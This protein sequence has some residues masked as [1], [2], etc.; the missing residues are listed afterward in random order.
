V[1]RRVAGLLP[2]VLLPPAAFAVHQ[3]RFMLAFGA[4]A[5]AELHRTGHSYL[6]SVVPWLVALVGLAVGWML[7]GVGRALSG[8]RTAG[9][10]AVSLTGLW[11]LCTVALVAIYVTQ[12]SLEGL[13]ATGHP[14]GLAG[15]FGFGGWWAVFVAA[16]VGLV[17]A[18]VCH[19]AVWAIDTIATRRRA[20]LRFPAEP[21][22]VQVG[23]L[24]DAALV[25]LA[26]LADGWSGRGPP[27]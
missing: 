25:A 7:R 18:A 6:H 16:C 3:L 27:R 20:H 1:R 9:R 14:G 2:I 26:P 21:S 23:R 5:A 17:L 22:V 19:G 10:Y 15:I 13:F 4:G 11:V 8:Q 12:E 24:V